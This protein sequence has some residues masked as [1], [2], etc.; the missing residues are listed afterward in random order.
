MTFD[1]RLLTRAIFPVSVEHMFRESH[2]ILIMLNVSGDSCFCSRVRAT[3]TLRTYSTSSS[4]NI[5][6]R[7]D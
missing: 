4:N 2:R 6:L 7:L 1:S 5:G 3:S